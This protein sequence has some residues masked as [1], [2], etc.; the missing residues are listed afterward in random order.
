MS[1]AKKTL[2]KEHDKET[3]DV[4][5]MKGYDDKDKKEEE[6]LGSSVASSKDSGVVKEE[7][8]S[9]WKIIFE[10][11]SLY[12]K[13]E[14][15]LKKI[16]EWKKIKEKCIKE[17]HDFPN[18]TDIFKNK[19][20]EY[21]EFRIVVSEL[22]KRFPILIREY[23]YNKTISYLKMSNMEVSKCQNYIV[24]KVMDHS[25]ILILIDIRSKLI[26]IMLPYSICYRRKD[27]LTLNELIKK[28]KIIDNK[29]ESKL[30][31]IG[32]SKITEFIESNA[33]NDVIRIGSV[34]NNDKALEV[35]IDP[36]CD[37]CDF[38]QGRLH[39]FK[40]TIST[41][42]NSLSFNNKDISKSSSGYFIY[43]INLIY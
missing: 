5:S 37:C 35:L 20:N 27:I 11:I 38:F 2:S 8:Y 33:F 42:I 21:I 3:K 31:D 1:S 30:K 16:R 13:K 41:S 40:Q 26:N 25:Q 19:N 14:I 28:L 6:Q 10:E 22:K 34:I 17:G 18:I 15:L 7:S 23:I 12:L 39:Q 24:E 9:Y 4:S 32:F 43:I 29:Y 36:I